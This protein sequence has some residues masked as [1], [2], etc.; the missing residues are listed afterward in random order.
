MS[1]KATG[2]SQTTNVLST[3]SVVATVAAMAIDTTAVGNHILESMDI[4]CKFNNYFTRT[5]SAGSTRAMNSDGISSRSMIAAK[6]MAST[7]SKF[8]QFTLTGTND[9]K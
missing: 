1:W 7:V 4:A 2:D 8:S 5:V 6:A 3:G 9:T